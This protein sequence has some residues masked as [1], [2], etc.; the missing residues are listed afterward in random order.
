MSPEEQRALEDF[1]AAVRAYYGANLRDVLMYGSRARGDDGP[2]SDVDL[3][4]ILKDGE[5]RRTP[6]LLRMAD[7]SYDALIQVGL[8]IHAMPIRESAWT[9]PESQ[10]NKSFLLAVRRDGRPIRIAA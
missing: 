10:P 5:W 7:M 3:A 1:V 4:V 8:S 9:T 2:N 6:E